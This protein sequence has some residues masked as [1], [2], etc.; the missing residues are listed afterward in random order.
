L[1]KGGIYRHFDSKEQLSAEAFEY[2]WRE[3]LHTRM[4]DLE[5]SS[6]TV[7]WLKQFIDNFVCR[8][9]SVP[10]GCPLLHTAVDADDG[11]A[12]LRQLA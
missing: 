4:H 5:E 2:A 6:D 10:G 9:S 7:E 8:R 3:A 12:G 1:E 11:S